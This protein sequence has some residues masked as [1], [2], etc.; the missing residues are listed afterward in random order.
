MCIYNQHE[1]R[2]WDQDY[3]LYVEDWEPFILGKAEGFMTF[4]IHCIEVTKRDN[5]W[6]PFSANPCMVIVIFY[7]VFNLLSIMIYVHFSS[8]I[9]SLIHFLP[10]IRP[11]NLVL[12]L[13]VSI[14]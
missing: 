7:D 13:N 10:N 6:D 14:S 12:L 5:I 9:I 8:K 1:H 11:S 4:G 2:T 3:V